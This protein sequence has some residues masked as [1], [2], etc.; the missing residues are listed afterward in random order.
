MKLHSKYQPHWQ[1]LGPHFRTA[2]ISTG[3][4]LVLASEL[5]KSPLAAAW[6]SLQKCSNLHWQQLGP[7]FR[8]A[9]ISTGN[10]LVLASEL[11]KSPLATAWSSLQKCSNLHWQQLG[12]RFRSAQI[13]TGSLVLASELLKAL[14]FCVCACD[15]GLPEGRRTSW[16]LQEKVQ[17]I[18]TE[19]VGKR[20]S[21]QHSM[22]NCKIG[23]TISAPPDLDM[24]SHQKMH[25]PQPL[26]WS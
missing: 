15:T 12:P 2:Q 7:R 4:S 16:I 23:I 22:S 1:L 3:N 10:S 25:S 14:P 5:L 13:S 26:T 18:H 8:T 20:S 6:S 24:H 21:H 11:F 9:Q 19:I 17:P